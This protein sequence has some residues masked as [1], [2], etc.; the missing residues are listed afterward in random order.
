MDNYNLHPLIHKGHIYVEI[1]WGTYG[2]LQASTIANIQ[3][4]QVL[5]PHGYHPCPLTPGL[6]THTTRDIHFILVVDNFVICYTMQMDV[7]HLLTTL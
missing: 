3:L 5:E 7:D 4:Q 6:W 2:L 1:R